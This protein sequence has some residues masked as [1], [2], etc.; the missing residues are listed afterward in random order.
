MKN[1]CVVED[2]EQGNQSL[3]AFSPAGRSRQC[4][5][6]TRIAGAAMHHTLDKVRDLRHEAHQRL[7]LATETGNVCT[8]AQKTYSGFNA[9]K[10]REMLWKCLLKSSTNRCQVFACG[11]RLP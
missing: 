10:R 7:L 1:Q 3:Q 8:F 6:E 11:Q 4:H 5:P 2:V 9:T